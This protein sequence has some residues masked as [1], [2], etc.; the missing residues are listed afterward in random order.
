[1]IIPTNK[2]AIAKLSINM[3]L[4]VLNDF[5]TIKHKITEEFPMTVAKMRQDMK[6]AV[7]WYSVAVISQMSAPVV[8]ESL[9]LVPFTS[10]AVQ[11]L[12]P[13]FDLFVAI[14]RSQAD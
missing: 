3:L 13:V 1:M 14:T 10:S 8:V 11:L 5:S 4:N 7:T 9:A 6:A 12:K 2:S